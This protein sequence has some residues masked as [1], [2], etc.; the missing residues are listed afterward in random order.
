MSKKPRVCAS[1]QTDLPNLRLDIHRSSTVENR[2]QDIEYFFS[3]SVNLVQFITKEVEIFQDSEVG[4]VFDM[5]KTRD[6]C[7]FEMRQFSKI[8]RET[9]ILRK[10]I[11]D[12]FQSLTHMQHDL[13]EFKMDLAKR[14]FKERTSS[15][16]MQFQ[17]DTLAI[18]M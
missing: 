4:Y 13:L 14:H 5:R 7:V 1:L 6:G 18:D 8:S 17:T 3:S 9:K 2:A 10:F 11:V 16:E 12:S 15:L